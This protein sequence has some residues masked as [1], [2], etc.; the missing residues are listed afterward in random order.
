M[1]EIKRRSGIGIK[2]YFF[3]IVTILAAVLGTALISYYASADQID[4]FYK[5]ATLSNARIFASMIDADFFSELRETVESDEYQALR[6]TAEEEDSEDIIRGYLQEKGLWEGY[7]TASGLL[8]KYL[9][10]SDVVKYLYVVVN[11]EA[12][13]DCDMLIM[14]DANNPIYVTG[15]FEENESEFSGVDIS[16]I[17]EPTISNGDWGWLCSAYAPVFS[18]DGRLICHVGC[19][20]SMDTVMEERRQFLITAILG[21]LGFTVFV[22]LIAVLLVNRAVVKPL[23]SITTEMKK[24]RPAENASYDEAGV[25]DLNIRSGDEI[26][27]I[28]E[29]IRKMQT[30]II[31]YLNDVS[32]LQ[33]DNEQAQ[34]DIRAKDEQIG[35]IS[36]EAYK[37]A[38]TGVGSK[39][40]YNKAVSELNEKI[41]AGE[42]EFAV[43]MV[44]LNDLKKVND[45][46]GHKAGDTYIKG[47][48]HLICDIFKHSPVF[49]IG[50]DEF[51]AILRDTDYNER[52]DK[53]GK[54]RAAFDI[55]CKD[56]S[57]KPWERYSAAVGIAENASDDNSYDLVFKRADKAM[58]EAKKEFKDKNGSYR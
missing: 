43:V 45:D 49:R 10:N 21:A 35:A 1:N 27:D 24:F 31:D 46:H 15:T 26:Q 47:S 44:D 25:I 32:A 54:L 55:T 18:E 50:G 4:R 2:L 38:L 19:D 56:N 34:N 53:V 8:N 37:D 57:R 39:A 20:V 22:L 11:D 17:I 6:D 28:Y 29:G 5:T 48:C 42:A 16:G 52:M 14:D 7:S 41:A 23:N 33:R 40:A 30:D 58:Y 12:Y 9:Q 51:V 3:I 13:E 36:K